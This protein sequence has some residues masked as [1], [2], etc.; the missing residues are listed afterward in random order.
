MRRPKTN[1]VTI[2]DSEVAYV[3]DGSQI[4]KHDEWVVKRVAVG[5]G[6]NQGWR[7][8]GVNSS[9]HV[10]VGEDVIESQGFDCSPEFADGGR[11]TPKVDLGVCNTNLHG[12]QLPISCFTILRGGRL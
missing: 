5:I 2:G 1:Y 4:G 11:I 3:S 8:I 10:V 9:E 6:I 12:Q 7:S